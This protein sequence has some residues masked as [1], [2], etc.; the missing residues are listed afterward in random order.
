LYQYQIPAVAYGMRSSSSNRG[1]LSLVP[2][3]AVNKER[4][5]FRSETC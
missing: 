5:H 2:E 4:E 1:R 3:S